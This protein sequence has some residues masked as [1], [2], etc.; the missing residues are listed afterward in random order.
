MTT[1]YRQAYKVKPVK[2]LVYLLYASNVQSEEMNG[3]EDE[4]Y[5]DYEVT[6][7]ENV[8]L[9]VVKQKPEHR[10]FIPLQLDFTPEECKEIYLAIVEYYDGCTFSETHGELAVAGVFKTNEEAEDRLKNLNEID[11][12]YAK[13][14]SGYFAGIDQSYVVKREIKECV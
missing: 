14:W 12:Y 10:S 2:Y 5:D 8:I 7:L 4:S 9:D 1:D 11:T 13:P 3:C 6:R